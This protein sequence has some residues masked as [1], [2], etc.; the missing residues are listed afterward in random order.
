VKGSPLAARVAVNRVWQAV[1][2][3]GLVEAIPEAQLLELE[4]A[5]DAD[6]DGISGRANRVWSHTQHRAVIGRIGWKAN[7]PDS[8]HQTAGAFAAEIGMSTSLR[9]GQ[10]CAPKQT[11][12]NEA[13]NGGE[14]EISDE[15]FKRIVDYQRMLAAPARR[16]L[17]SPEVQRGAELFIEAQCTKCHRAQLT[18]GEIA[19]APWLSKQKIHP[20]SDF[21]LHDMGE[22][23]ADGHADFDATGREWRTPPLWGLG[24]QHA[25]NG[26]T[27]LLHDG[28]ARNVNEAILWHGG[29]AERAKEAYRATPKRDRDA[30]LAFLSSL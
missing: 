6:G 1:F 11:L 8:A 7:Q 4:D 14:P 23:L 10:N 3:L 28:R 9:P 12:C 18:T 16:N 24:L 2:G 5:N 26:H 22:A 20:F 27:R 17:D 30:L 15:I 25:V 19:D 29:E 13:P 21:L